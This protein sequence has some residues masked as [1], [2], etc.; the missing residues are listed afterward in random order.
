M[1]NWLI[2]HWIEISVYSFIICM[3]IGIIGLLILF[4]FYLYDKYKWRKWKK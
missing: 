4:G 2:E 1:I 3:G